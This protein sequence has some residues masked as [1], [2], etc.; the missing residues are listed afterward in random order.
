MII[1]NKFLFPLL[2]TLGLGF[3]SGYIFS[4]RF[5]NV[6][7]GSRVETGVALNQTLRKFFSQEA[8]WMYTYLKSLILDKPENQDIQSLMKSQQEITNLMGTYFGNTINRDLGILLN[9]RN[10]L[11][12]KLA[13]AKQ[14]QTSTIEIQ[15]DWA[16]NSAQ[17]SNLIEEQNPNFKRA[18]KEQY[19]IIDQI[20]D[21]LIAKD[22]HIANQSA[23]NHMDTSLEI[24]DMIDN[25]IR[26]QFA[27]KF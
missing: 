20:I 14:A 2:I 4:S 21:A 18:L 5:C 7:I 12:K 6:S 19:L 23:L 27:N 1:Q 16:I 3:A 11:I 26:T 17:I 25:N 8:F 10:E 22:W 13:Q 9:Q 15:A 24:A